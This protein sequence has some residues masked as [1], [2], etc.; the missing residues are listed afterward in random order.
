[1]T[2]NKKGTYLIDRFLRFVGVAC[3]TDV[4]QAGEITCGELSGEGPNQK[5]RIAARC[6][7]FS[8]SSLMK[9]NFQRF[10]N[11]KTRSVEQVFLICRSGEI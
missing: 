6:R 5:D 8:F 2:V 4:I 3:P 11:K 9:V 10:E 1:M 7:A